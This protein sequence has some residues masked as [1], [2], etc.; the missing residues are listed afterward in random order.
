[1]KH[2][3]ETRLEREAQRKLLPLSERRGILDIDKVV[4]VSVFKVNVH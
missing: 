4:N 2:P 1:M 3:F